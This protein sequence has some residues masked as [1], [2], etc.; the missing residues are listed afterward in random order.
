MADKGITLAEAKRQVAAIY[1]RIGMPNI[2]YHLCVKYA[3]ML[4]ELAGALTTTGTPRNP[5]LQAAITA[6]VD[7]CIDELEGPPE[8]RVG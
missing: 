3:Y 6:L 5:K 8:D 1:D 7:M 2:L 4:R